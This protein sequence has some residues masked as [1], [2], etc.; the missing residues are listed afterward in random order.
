MVSTD[1][2]APGDAK[3]YRSFRDRVIRNARS[4]RFYRMVDRDEL[5]LGDATAEL[6]ADMEDLGR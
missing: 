6:L 2:L 5:E 4:G 1:E 3:A